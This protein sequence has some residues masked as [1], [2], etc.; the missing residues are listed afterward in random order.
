MNLEQ[1]LAHHSDETMG[2][3]D[4]VWE[5]VSSG[6]Y[7]YWR[8]DAH[9]EALKALRGADMLSPVTVEELPFGAE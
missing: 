9:Y 8:R 2:S 4:I 6:N 5:W 3:C 1:L 7:G